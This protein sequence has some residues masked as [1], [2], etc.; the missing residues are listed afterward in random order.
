MD[1]TGLCIAFPNNRPLTQRERDLHLKQNQRLDIKLAWELS[2]VKMNSSHLI[3]VDRWYGVR[4]SLTLVGLAIAIMCGYFAVIMAWAPISGDVPNENGLWAVLFGGAAG[5]GACVAMGLWF[6][7]KEMF[8]WTY[9]PIALDRT[10]RMVHVFRLNGTTLSVPWDQIYFTLGRGGGF[11]ALNWDLRGLVL[12]KDGVTVRDTF[13]FSVL[14]QDPDIVRGHWEFLRRYME[15]GPKGIA[16]MVTT[17]V[18]LDGQ[19]EP[20]EFGNARIFIKDRGLPTLIKLTMVP[21]NVLHCIARWAVMQTSKVPVF[22]DA[23]MRTLQT[24]LDDPYL[25]DASMNVPG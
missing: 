11:G 24:D 4:G 15:Q 23:V 12:D 14:A 25:R 21:F 7:S 19:R 5:C 18:P 2:L 20:F 13:A 17:C 8:R 10:N 16:A 22:P 6:V 9:Y 1:N 3:S